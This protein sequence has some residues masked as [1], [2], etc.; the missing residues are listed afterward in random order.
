M[1]Q[2]F[3]SSLTEYFRE[4]EKRGKIPH[5]DFESLA[6]TVFS[7]TFGYTFLSASFQETLSKTDRET[8]IKNSVTL[9]I[10]GVLRL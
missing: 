5:A 2:V 10:D 7:A 9:F 4:M 8:Y 6:M 1:P 3:V